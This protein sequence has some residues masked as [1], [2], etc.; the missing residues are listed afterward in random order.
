MIDTTVIFTFFQPP[1][2][3]LKPTEERLAFLCNLSWTFVEYCVECSLKI[4]KLPRGYDREKILAIQDSFKVMKAFMLI[5][6]LGFNANVHFLVSFSG[7]I[8]QK[9]SIFARAGD[10][11]EGAWTNS[12]QLPLTNSPDP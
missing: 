7:G 2:S 5:I 8:K 11:K 12:C 3:D 9:M 1:F 10:G 4:S 6:A